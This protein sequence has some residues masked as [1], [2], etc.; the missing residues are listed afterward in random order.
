[1]Q[2]R[3]KVGDPETTPRKH[4]DRKFR[5]RRGERA[6]AGELPPSRRADFAAQGLWAVDLSI[7]ILIMILIIIEYRKLEAIRQL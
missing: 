5:K 6:Q 7:R 4:L 2:A 1:M 3:S